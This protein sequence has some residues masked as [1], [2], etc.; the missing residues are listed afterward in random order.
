MSG[1]ET[2]QD[3]E[4]SPENIFGW[5]ADLFVLSSVQIIHCPKSVCHSVCLSVTLSRCMYYHTVSLQY[6]FLS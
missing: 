3:R 2:V 5:A 4:S 6:D 1:R